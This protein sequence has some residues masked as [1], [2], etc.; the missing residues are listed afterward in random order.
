MS[1][2]NIRNGEMFFQLTAALPLV[3][4]P[5]YVG[6]GLWLLTEAPHAWETEVFVEE[7]DRCFP[8]H[9]VDGCSV[10]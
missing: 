9:R 7:G 1:G 3:T 8:S 6:P 5:R 4:A 2:F 10:V